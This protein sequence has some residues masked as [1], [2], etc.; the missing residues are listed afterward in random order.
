M[1]N[2]KEKVPTDPFDPDFESIIDEDN[3][4]PNATFERLMN[5]P[6]HQG[7]RRKGRTPESEN[8]LDNEIDNILGKLREDKQID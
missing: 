3:P 2:D 7:K 5:T 6:L 4:Y 8:A 1:D